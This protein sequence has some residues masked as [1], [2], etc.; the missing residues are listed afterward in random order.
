MLPARTLQPRDIIIII[1]PNRTN[2]HRKKEK[3]QKNDSQNRRIITA[4]SPGS[5]GSP[6]RVTQSAFDGCPERCWLAAAIS[7]RPASCSWHFWHSECS[8]EC[9]A[10]NR[11]AVQNGQW[12][13]QSLS[14]RADSDTRSDGN[15]RGSSGAEL[16]LLR[17]TGY[18]WFTLAVGGRFLGNVRLWLVGWRVGDEHWRC[19]WLKVV[20]W[21]DV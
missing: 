9:S 3:T 19:R 16:S 18:Y 8:A 15:T 10:E 2:N 21:E 11:K 4:S 13:V 17:V 5:P 7:S 14:D 20:G 6:T 12:P 1:L